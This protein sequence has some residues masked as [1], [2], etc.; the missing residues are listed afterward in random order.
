M[1]ERGGKKR[2]EGRD[3]KREENTKKQFGALV[4]KVYVTRR[5]TRRSN[6][7]APKLFQLEDIPA[8]PWSLSIWKERETLKRMRALALAG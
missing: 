3:A 4:Y 5:Y 1:H 7:G 2:Q 8:T 6:M